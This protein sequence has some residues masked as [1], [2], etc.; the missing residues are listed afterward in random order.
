MKKYVKEIIKLNIYNMILWLMCSFLLMFFI[1]ETVTFFGQ[2]EF[3]RENAKFFL[4]APFM[5]SIFLPIYRK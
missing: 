4:I 5:I 1:S 2:L 3:I